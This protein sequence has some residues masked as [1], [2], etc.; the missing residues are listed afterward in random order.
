MKNIPRKIRRNH[1]KFYMGKRTVVCTRK[2]ERAQ[3]P[4]VAV[5]KRAKRDLDWLGACRELQLCGVRPRPEGRLELFDALLQR[6][7]LPWRTEPSKP[8]LV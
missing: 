1:V 5:A 4:T 2:E 7:D 8:E 3:T 6:E